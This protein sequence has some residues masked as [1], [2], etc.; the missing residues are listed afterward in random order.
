MEKINVQLTFEDRII[1][2]AN[3]LNISNRKQNK[4]VTFYNL[5][6]VSCE[7]IKKGEHIYIDIFIGNNRYTDLDLITIDINSEIPILEGF[8]NGELISYNQFELNLIKDWNEGM[9]LHDWQSFTLENKNAW[10]HA[11]SVYAVW[12]DTTK[13]KEKIII[14]GK[15][16]KCKEDF[17]CHLGEAFYIGIGYMGRTLDGLDDCLDLFRFKGTNNRVLIIQHVEQL[18][19]VLNAVK[20]DYFDNVLEILEK[21]KF[22][23]EIE[24]CSAKPPTS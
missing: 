14:N 15:L 1:A 4:L 2:D 23:I 6:N 13:L 21:Y 18:Q 16:V 5:T 8:F 10:I 19:K 9:R 12:G 24:P 11:S 3:F 17:Y 22:I 20:E 7:N